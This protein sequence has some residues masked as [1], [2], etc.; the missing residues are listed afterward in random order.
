MPIT[1]NGK[2]RKV[3]KARASMI[4]LFDNG[5]GKCQNAALDQLMQQGRRLAD[6]NAET[7]PGVALSDQEIVDAYLRERGQALAIDPALF[8]APVSDDAD[9]HL[10]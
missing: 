7:R 10:R 5:Y 1:E 9:S 3:S 6:K 8:G 2:V 4:P